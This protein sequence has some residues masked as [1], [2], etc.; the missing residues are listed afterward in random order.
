MDQRYCFQ[1]AYSLIN[2]L[3]SVLHSLKPQKRYTING[4]MP[5]SVYQLKIEA[6]NVA[7]SSMAEFTFVTL[8]KDGGEFLKNLNIY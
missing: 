6:H 7:G 4:L 1:S 2:Y 3:L 8:T 5:A